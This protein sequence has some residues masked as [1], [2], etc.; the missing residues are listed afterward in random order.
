MIS[1][2]ENYEDRVL[3]NNIVLNYKDNT[4]SGYDRIDLHPRCIDFNLYFFVEMLNNNN[5]LF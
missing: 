5:T 1:T 2:S 4:V 3:Q